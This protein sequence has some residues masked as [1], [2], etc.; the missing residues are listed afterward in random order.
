[1]VHLK[2]FIPF[3][4]LMVVSCASLPPPRNP[5]AP[6]LQASIMEGGTGM[7]FGKNHAFFFTAPNG[8]VLDN[9]SGVSEG[10]HMLFYPVGYTWANTPVR[11][12]GRSR[13]KTPEIRNIQD[14]VEATIK[15]FHTRYKSPNYKS[16]RQ[17]PIQLP[18]GVK[19]EIYFF[20]GDQWGNY[21]AAGY[22]EEKETINFLV[23][24][25][26]TKLCFDS[27]L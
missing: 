8:W 15:E 9:Q 2:K 17:T 21:E 13:T 26:P 27:Y 25:S 23:F 1:M 22:I 18:D 6:S 10:V 7:L 16:E 5:Q 12:Y 19:I 4:M 11:V 14:Q 3:L 24:N 20:E